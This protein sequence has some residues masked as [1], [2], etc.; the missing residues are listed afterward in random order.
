MQDFHRVALVD[1]ID[2]HWTVVLF[3]LTLAAFAAPF[4]VTDGF[5]HVWLVVPFAFAWYW[6][7][8]PLQESSSPD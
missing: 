8:P 7:V 2:D 4:I 3:C 5:E 1:W 6:H